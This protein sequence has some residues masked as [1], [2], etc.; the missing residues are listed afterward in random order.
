MKRSK[1]NEAGFIRGRLIMTILWVAVGTTLLYYG[2]KYGREYYK[3]KMSETCSER[4]WIIEKAKEKFKKRFGAQSN[5]E[6]YAELL[7]FLPYAGLPMCPWGG[8]YQNVLDLNKQV[9]C[10]LNGKAEYEPVTP[11]EN[12][13]ANGYQDLA[14][15]QQAMGLAEFFSRKKAPEETAKK[16]SKLF[17]K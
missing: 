13:L 2:T 4:M 6:S 8:E 15:P 17:G 9:T 12:P 11:G 7:P 3:V 10:P 5:I 16:E 14:K 1:P